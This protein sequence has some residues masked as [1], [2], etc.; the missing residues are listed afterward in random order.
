MTFEWSTVEKFSRVKDGRFGGCKAF[1]ATPRHQ[2]HPVILESG[3]AAFP[4][5][6]LV[7]GDCGQDQRINII[8]PTGL[9]EYPSKTMRHFRLKLV[10]I[11]R[12][13]R[14]DIFLRGATRDL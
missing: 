11:D 13:K 8:L 1:S 4:S 12:R 9:D 10:W 3:G 14:P 6:G 7:G 2:S 5:A